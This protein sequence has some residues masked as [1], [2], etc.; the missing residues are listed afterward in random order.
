MN[1]LNASF[2]D[3][4]GFIFTSSQGEILRQINQIGAEEFDLMHDSGLYDSLVKKNFLIQHQEVENV[5][6]DA[7]KTIKPERITFH[8]ISLRMV[9][10]P[11]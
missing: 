3:P 8:F 11:T 4:A 2:R 10:W 9:F 6:A 1:K 7:Y 5:Y